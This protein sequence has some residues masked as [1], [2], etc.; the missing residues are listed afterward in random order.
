MTDAKELETW[1]LMKAAMLRRN[2][3]MK[4]VSDWMVL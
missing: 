2:K 1:R 3:A 4:A